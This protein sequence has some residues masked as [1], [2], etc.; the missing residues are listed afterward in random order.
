MMTHSI[1]ISYNRGD[2]Q[3]KDRLLFHLE[4]RRMQTTALPAPDGEGIV[5]SEAL[6]EGLSNAEAVILLVS[7]QFL[8][9]DYILNIEIPHVLA[10][11]AKEGLPVFPLIVAPC[12]WQTVEWLRKMQVFPRDGVPLSG[13]TTYEIEEVLEELAE[14]VFGRIFLPGTISMEFDSLVDK[15]HRASEPSLLRAEEKLPLVSIEG[16]VLKLGL[17]Q[18]KDTGP[19]FE[20][21]IQGNKPLLAVIGDSGSGKSILFYQVAGEP[22]N[23]FIVLFYDIHHLQSVGSLSSR[24]I[25]D[26]DYNLK[27]LDTL[28]LIFDRLFTKENKKL[29]ILLDGLNE[30]FQIEPSDLKTEIEVLG[31]KLPNSIK[32]SYSCRTVYWNSY[33]KVNSPI[34]S[35]L[36]HDSKEFLL[37]H[38]SLDEAE[39]AF[40]NYQNLYKFEGV[41]NLLRDDIKRKIRDPLMLR[42]LAEG[43]QG[44]RLPSFAPA[45]KIFRNFEDALKRKF[46]GRLFLMD[47]LYELISFKLDELNI[48]EQ[49]SILF[50]T[51]SVRRETRFLNYFQMAKPGDPFIILEDEGII[52]SLE[53]EHSIYMF[54]YDRFFEYLLGKEI[55][56]EF[57]VNS[58][59]EFVE[60]L[61][62]KI[63]SLQRHHYSFLAALKT[64]IIRLNINNPKGNWSFYDKKTLK[65]LL[66]N[67]DPAIVY[68]TKE[69]LRELAFEGEGDIFAALK[70]VA[71]DE[72]GWK[73]LALDIVGDSPE[74][75]PILLEG[76]FSGNRHFTRRSMA[77]L[78]VLNEDP[79]SRKNFET[80]MVDKIKNC[81]DFTAEHALGFLYYSAAIFSLEDRLGGDPIK[82][83]REFWRTILM[84]GQGGLG[85]IKEMIKTAFISIV[86]I[87]GPSFFSSIS[88]SGNGKED[89]ID[90]L[91]KVLSGK[92]KDAALKMVPLI[93]DDIP[94]D[95]E[96]EEIIR[97]FGS[98]VRYLD[99]KNK[100]KS[101]SRY[102]YSLEYKISQW[103][104]IQRSKSSYN[105]IK[106]ILDRYVETG[107]W[108][109]IKFALITMKSILQIIYADNLDILKDGFKQ[110]KVWTNNLEEQSNEF[111]SALDAAEPFSIDFIPI[112]P[113]ATIDALYF[114]PRNGPV[115]VLEE[116]L[117][118]GD[119]RKILLALL[120]TRS[121][122]KENPAK[123]LAT[124]E[125]ILGIKDPVVQTRLDRILREIYFEYPRMV[126]DF[127][128]K[129]QLTTDRIQTIKFRTDMVDV[130]GGGYDDTPLFKSL[131][132][133]SRE[134]RVQFKQWYTKLLNSPNLES[135]CD[136]FIDFL[137]E[138]TIK[139]P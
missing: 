12:P 61:C 130:I 139:N 60:L 116:R 73:L 113:V 123:I 90:Y 27:D 78:S 3:W 55:G 71:D 110:M 127:F 101:L 16:R 34:S 45:V 42:M 49:V 133:A 79:S 52:T 22:E 69:V 125:I 47:F 8:V 118:S 77:I 65:L 36:Y 37:H 89:G 119:L 121:L 105:N 29:L 30:S 104:I 1:Y 109:C 67:S 68:F 13:M 24:L 39:K 103:I 10:K 66:N 43:Y 91:W 63:Q 87:E 88:R 51:R 70:N 57:R 31:S 124:L 112:L 80:S 26:F 44:K 100:K 2:E 38:F 9:S 54:T 58:R 115:G 131:F 19:D 138:N 84:G 76:L 99:K 137:V 132:L 111:Y 33:I 81:A 97:F 11:R 20:R 75:Y 72:L 50:N 46:G 95:D 129:N 64:E 107:D 134:R 23:N 85:A 83:I 86:R 106:N 93:A 6:K 96:Y 48:V 32:I 136:S 98:Q 117:I 41:F 5:W 122:W 59:E 102:T 28:F 128:W 25:N 126:E 114:T 135:F 108:A 17:V 40:H 21:F 53:A 120:A 94:I 92:E 15:I 14:T 62:K 56:R 4:K 18:R 7:P 82:K 74:I 35:T